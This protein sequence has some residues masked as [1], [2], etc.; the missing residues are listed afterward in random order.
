MFADILRFQN[1]IHLKCDH[2]YWIS[3]SVRPC[4]CQYVRLARSKPNTWENMDRK[5]L[6]RETGVGSRRVTS[7]SSLLASSKKQWQNLSDPPI[8]VS[9]VGWLIGGHA[10]AATVG[11]AVIMPPVSCGTQIY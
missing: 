1:N 11:L 8:V 10:V 3:L 2:T 9:A 5:Q 7:Q 6:G 4:K